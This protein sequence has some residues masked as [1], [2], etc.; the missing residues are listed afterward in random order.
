MSEVDEKERLRSEIHD[1][2]S[3]ASAAHLRRLKSAI[4]K[5]RA[6][7][8]K[9][10]TCVPRKEPLADWQPKHGGLTKAAMELLLCG[11]GIET[12][13][14]KV[15]EGEW[16][17]KFF[18]SRIS[19]RLAHDENMAEQGKAIV[20]K[21]SITVTT[22][23]ARIVEEANA[24]KAAD[25]AFKDARLE[26]QGSRDDPGWLKATTRGAGVVMNDHGVELFALAAKRMAERLA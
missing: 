10:S 15:T 16:Q 19:Q 14:F 9:V 23:V 12:A 3:G 26:M 21:S 22:L 17:H 6:R 2:L 5:R 13:P 24:M 7:A 11:S 25:E 8:P 18:V 20:S 4:E 1:M